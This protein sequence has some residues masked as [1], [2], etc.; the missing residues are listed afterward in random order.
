MIV[1]RFPRHWLFFF[2]LYLLCIV[3]N[4]YCSVTNLKY[5]KIIYAY[6]VPTQSTVSSPNLLRS[7]IHPSLHLRSDFRPYFPFFFIL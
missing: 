3:N 6:C 5:S 4:V 7:R 1:I 2:Y